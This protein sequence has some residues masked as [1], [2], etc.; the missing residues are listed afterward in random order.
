MYQCTSKSQ[1]LRLDCHQCEICRI[2]SALGVLRSSVAALQSP[3]SAA[4][5]ARQ[6]AELDQ[7]RFSR[8]F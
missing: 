8:K 4:V 6:R 7:L 2:S 3:R 5:A 1:I